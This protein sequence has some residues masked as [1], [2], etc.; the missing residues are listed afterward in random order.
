MALEILVI[1]AV[2]AMGAALLD[3]IFGNDDDS[4]AEPE[5][6]GGDNFYERCE[7]LGVG[8]ARDDQ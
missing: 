6:R 2:L 5:E 3:G 4:E 7:Q 8:S 1:P